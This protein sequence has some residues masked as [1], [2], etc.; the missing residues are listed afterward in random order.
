[1]HVNTG[2]GSGP[3]SPLIPPQV[4]GS[5]SP[6]MDVRRL[7]TAQ[8]LQNGIGLGSQRGKAACWE[9]LAFHQ[10]GGA[11]QLEP[12]PLVPWSSVTL[13]NFCWLSQAQGHKQALSVDVNRG[14][15]AF[16]HLKRKRKERHNRHGHQALR[17]CIDERV[18]KLM[19]AGWLAGFVT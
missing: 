16:A 5:L 17:H 1:M 8:Q 3:R 9:T 14:S 13:Y 19:G 2:T 4:S 15:E 12:T 10:R 18:R 6:E 7:L 11:P